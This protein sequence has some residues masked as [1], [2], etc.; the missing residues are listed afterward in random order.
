[1]EV[2]VKSSCRRFV[3]LDIT[4]I[5]SKHIKH[6]KCKEDE[7]VLREKFFSNVHRYQLE[8]LS[9]EFAKGEAY[10]DLDEEERMVLHT[11]VQLRLIGLY[12]GKFE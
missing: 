5:L 9:A 6:V 4:R 10:V 3:Y 8:I 2:V 1:M 11:R 7:S 12:A